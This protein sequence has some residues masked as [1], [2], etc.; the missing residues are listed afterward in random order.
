MLRAPQGART[1]TA[2]THEPTSHRHR[3]L[4]ALD[5][6]VKDAVVPRGTGEGGFS[7]MAA[8]LR[9]DEIAFGVCACTSGGQRKHFFLTWAGPAVSA[10]KKGRV[11]MQKGGAS[12]C[13]AE[14]GEVQPSIKPAGVRCVHSM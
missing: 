10:I 11:S 1:A 7:E 14:D 13:V 5:P 8:A 2:T 9:D 12:R 6:A 3:V 4:C